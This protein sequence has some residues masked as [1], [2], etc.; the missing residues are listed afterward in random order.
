MFDVLITVGTKDF[1]KFRFVV[2]SIEKNV[3]GYYRI[4]CIM[5]SPMPDCYRAEGVTY[6]NDSDVIDFDFTKINMEYRRGWYRQQFIKLF[7]E[8]TT[9]NYLVVDGDVCLNKP[10]TINLGHPHFYLGREQY[11]LPYFKFLKDVLDLERVY[12]HSFISEIMLFKRGMISYMLDQ[13]H[14]DKHGFFDLAVSE[15][16]KINDASG[17][18][19][20]ELYGNYVSKHWPDAYQY[21]PIRVFHQAKK[22]EWTIDEIGL[23]IHTYSKSTY[24]LFTMH[25]WI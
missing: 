17:F 4:I 21:R 18:S 6:Y 8:V 5:Q 10:L 24:D 20:Y 2:K 11:H 23:Y 3:K 22:R 15:I 12:P 16:N 25:S 19:E 7:Q 1:N 9:D 14:V 13:L